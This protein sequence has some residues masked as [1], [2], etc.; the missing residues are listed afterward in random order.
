MSA[1]L[2]DRAPASVT[3]AL[4][5]Q[6][7]VAGR[8]TVA[9]DQLSALAVDGAI[10]EYEIETVRQEQ[11]LADD[12]AGDAER[13]GLLELAEW[14]GTDAKP[15]LEVRSTSTRTGR[16]VRELTLPELV[17]AVHA[18]GEVVAVFPC[19]DGDRRWSVEDALESL[20]ASGGLPD[21]V[22]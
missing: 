2:A 10:G 1:P 14:R 12:G 21:G 17:L 4:Y 13:A 11:V 7:P 9:I 16:P 22:R 5:A 3:L 20:G 18:N 8:R 15:D 19:T 6:T